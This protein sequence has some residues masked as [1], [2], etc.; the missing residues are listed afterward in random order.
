MWFC[1]P[2]ATTSRSSCLG[3]HHERASRAQ[4]RPTSDTSSLAP[5]AGGTI[6]TRAGRHQ[7]LSQSPIHN[8]RNLLGIVLGERRRRR[9][10]ISFALAIWV[11][12][13]S[14]EYVLHLGSSDQMILD[15]A[16]V[17]HSGL[18][19]GRDCQDCAMLRK[20]LLHA[21]RRPRQAVSLLYLQRANCSRASQAPR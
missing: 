15:H 2:A 5:S 7:G 17:N 12:L 13:A 18:L 21:L 4:I 6:A 16:I 14:R 9:L 20:Y 8:V 1:R 19:A 3:R 11:A 10:V